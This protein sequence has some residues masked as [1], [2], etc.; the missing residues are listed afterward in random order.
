MIPGERDSLQV[1]HDRIAARAGDK[2]AQH[3]LG[4]YYA[5]L[6]AAEEAAAQS[7]DPETAAS[8]ATTSP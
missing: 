7:E 2:T 4:V 1:E 3:N 8:D 5:S 6:E